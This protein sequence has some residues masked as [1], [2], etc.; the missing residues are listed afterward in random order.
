MFKNRSKSSHYLHFYILKSSLSYYFKKS[1]NTDPQLYYTFIITVLH[2][3]NLFLKGG[4]WDRF[5]KVLLIKWSLLIDDPPWTER[6]PLQQDSIYSE[7]VLSS[8]SHVSI[9]RI[10]DVQKQEHH[11]SIIKDYVIFNL[12]SMSIYLLYF[13]IHIKYVLWKTLITQQGCYVS[14]TTWLV[15]LENYS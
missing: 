6:P 2:S 7:P 5:Q 3:R 9:T 11:F 12:D 1:I 13:L 10:T 15:S 8:T 14:Y 4:R